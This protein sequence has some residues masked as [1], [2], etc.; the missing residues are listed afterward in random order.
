MSVY[1]TMNCIV[2]FIICDYFPYPYPFPFVRVKEDGG[3]FY[4]VAYQSNMGHLGL[5]EVSP[6]GELLSAR[7]I[8]LNNHPWDVFF[9]GHYEYFSG[10]H[11]FLLEGIENIN[12]IGE[13]KLCFV[14]F[15]EDQNIVWGRD[16]L[17]EWG[18]HPIAWLASHQGDRIAFPY[19]GGFGSPY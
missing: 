6:D 5:L 11:L 7:E 12:G 9:L 1:C 17:F 8:T 14:V 10:K 3:S 13:T 4:A 16:I 19:G 15:D 2:F 18:I